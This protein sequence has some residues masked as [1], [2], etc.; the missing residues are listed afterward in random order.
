M[1][2]RHKHGMVTPAKKN[3]IPGRVVAL[4]S[5]KNKMT[6][7]T[8]RLKPIK[9]IEK[10]REY[11]QEEYWE[12]GKTNNVSGYES[13]YIDWDWNDKLVIHLQEAFGIKDKTILDLGC[14]YGQVIAALTKAGIEA[15]GIDISD[16][17]ISQGKKE[18]SPLEER[19]FQGSCHDL[20]LF[21]DNSFDFLYSNQVF[22]HIP[23]QYCK[24]LAR[25]TFRVAKH[26]TLLWAGL[27]LDLSEEFQP[28]GFN[29]KDPDKTHINLRP[30]EWWD[31]IFLAAGWK[32]AYDADAK[33]RSVKIDEYSFFK[34]YGWHSIC[35]RKG[36]I[37]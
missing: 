13:F 21:K 32:E 20:T 25:E 17:A 6:T 3:N 12:K 35:Y 15:K 28:Q 22:E 33:F 24:E 9:T 2:T 10:I 16:Y 7:K 36:I 34:D 23:Y 14:A 5:K 4:H 8:I 29:P 31:K 19:I 26:G 27:V 1:T 30:K 18:Y 11:I 37:Q